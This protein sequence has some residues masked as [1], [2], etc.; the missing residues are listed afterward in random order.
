MWTYRE[1]EDL[2][3]SI[4]FLFLNDFFKIY[5]FRKLSFPYWQQKNPSAC[6]STYAVLSLAFKRIEKGWD[7]LAMGRVTFSL[8]VL[9][10]P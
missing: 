1:I 2:I 8:Q 3:V 4:V 5:V 7:F 9:K 6:E 10:F